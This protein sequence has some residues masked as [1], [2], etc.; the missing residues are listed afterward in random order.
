MFGNRLTLSAGW[1]V[2]VVIGLG[3]W[4]GSGAVAAESVA[5]AIS[6]GPRESGPRRLTPPKYDPAAGQKA[7]RQYGEKLDKVPSLLSA[8]KLLDAA[9][10]GKITADKINARIQAWRDSKLG[11]MPVRWKVAHNGKPLAKAAV[12]FE[13]EEFLG[14]DVKEGKGT[15]DA[16]GMCSVAVG[17]TTPWMAPG[18]YRVKVTKNGENIPAKY[19]TETTLGQEV[20]I[21]NPAFR[22][23]TVVF[24]LQY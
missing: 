20:A 5:S 8:G 18:F 17:E 7:V 14:A 9:G 2:G 3:V 13:P 19:N 23:G 12:L 24:N 6:A 22:S 11:G 16:N 15:T 10:D 21:D 4:A 1:V